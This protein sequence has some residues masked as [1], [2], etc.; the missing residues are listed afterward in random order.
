[1]GVSPG[2]SQ[3]LNIPLFRT[4]RIKGGFNV[5]RPVCRWNELQPA[6]KLSAESVTDFKH[7]LRRMLLNVYFRQPCIVDCHILFYYFISCI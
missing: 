4:G 6:L 2:H 7:R 1:M 5:E 3:L